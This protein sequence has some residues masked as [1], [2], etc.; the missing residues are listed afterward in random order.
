MAQALDDFRAVSS[1]HGRELTTQHIGP[2]D[3]ELIYR[4][5]WT[6][7]N[8]DF[9]QFRELYGKNYTNQRIETLSGLARWAIG[10][11]WRPEL[12]LIDFQVANLASSMI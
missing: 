11:I 6:H 9:A 7:F 2:V 12:W 1:P 8:K 4:L 10:K 3:D 5:I